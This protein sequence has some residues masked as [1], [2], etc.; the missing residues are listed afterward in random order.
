MTPAQ[1][2]QR[3]ALQRMAWS[4]NLHLRGIA[5]EVMMVGS[6]SSVRSTELTTIG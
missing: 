6:V 5:V 3:L 2:L 1:D 4:N